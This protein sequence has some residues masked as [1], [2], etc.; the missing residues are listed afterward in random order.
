MVFAS[1]IWFIK[2]RFRIFNDLQSSVA[3]DFIR[4]IREKYMFSKREIY[5]AS[6]H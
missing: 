3:I 4:L 5:E 6:D 2:V 1:N